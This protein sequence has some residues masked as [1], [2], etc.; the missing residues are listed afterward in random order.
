MTKNDDKLLQ[1]LAEALSE[2]TPVARLEEHHFTDPKAIVCK[3][4]GSDDIIK[5]GVNEEGIQNYICQKC[6]RKFNAKDAPYGM[7]TEVDQIG[8]SLNMYYTG[9]SL[10]DIAN[11]LKVTYNNPVDRST[12]YRWLIKFTTEAIKV[13]ANV[14]PKV[15]D[16]WIADETAI[17]FSDKLYWIWDIIDRQTRFLV[18]SYLS[19]NRGTRE[20]KMLMDLAAKRAGKI[21]HKVVTDKLKAYLDGIELAF[22]ADTRHIQSSPFSHEDSTNIIERFQGTIKERTKVIWGFKSLTTARLIIDGFLIHYN[23]FRPHISLNSKTP[24][25]AAHVILP[26]KNWSELVRKVGGIR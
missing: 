3:W 21:P 6:G 2:T 14:R 5:H 24:A 26:C 20:A 1:Q 11:Q 10:S 25:E 8:M 13:F 4:C 15:S 19:P 18:A 9:S 17:K 23:Y 7:R 22:G 12:V 16:T